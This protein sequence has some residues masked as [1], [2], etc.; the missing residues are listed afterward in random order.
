MFFGIRPM[1]PT[2]REALMVVLQPYMEWVA[3]KLVQEVVQSQVAAAIC[4]SAAEQMAIERAALQIHRLLP[5]IVNDMIDLEVRWTAPDIAKE[6][7]I[8]MAE[9]LVEERRIE[10]VWQLA[11]ETWSPELI[12]D[13]AWSALVD[14][15]AMTLTIELVNEVIAEVAADC[16]PQVIEIQTEFRRA[17]TLKKIRSVA[18]EHMVNVASLRY[19]TNVLGSNAL[20]LLVYRG[21]F[22]RNVADAV[23]YLDAVRRT[24]VEPRNR[25]ASEPLLA[26]AYNYICRRPVIDALEY[27]LDVAL[28][29]YD[30]AI[31]RIEDAAAKDH[32][33]ACHFGEENHMAESPTSGASPSR[34]GTSEAAAF[35]T[36]RRFD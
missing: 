22:E 14:I 11:W 30:V 17:S 18:R 4:E 12:H 31:Q 36:V 15:E 2:A 28:E 20:S 35:C 3:S 29:C 5:T 24:T 7:I 19:L 21:L 6:V 1:G 8:E 25:M 13:V 33:N 23:S 16:Y 32:V 34:V 10:Q 27:D 9:N 26:H